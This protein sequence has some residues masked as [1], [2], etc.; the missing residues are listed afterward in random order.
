MLPAKRGEVAGHE[1]RIRAEIGRRVEVL[2]SLGAR[3]LTSV[4]SELERLEAEE[5]QLKKSLTEIAKRQA[6]VERIGD[7]A[8]ALL[9][10]WQDVGDTRINPP[11]RTA[12]RTE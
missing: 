3:G 9:E 6:Q 5:C 2:K 10:T 1:R 8:R 4:Q 7:E 12:L 11:R